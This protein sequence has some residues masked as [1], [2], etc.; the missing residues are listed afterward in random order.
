[1][2]RERD[3]SEQ[4][5]W[6]NAWAQSTQANLVSAPEPLAGAASPGA[7]QP[8]APLPPASE[9]VRS[10][11]DLIRNSVPISV[12]TPTST[13]GRVVGQT[14]NSR[15]IKTPPAAGGRATPLHMG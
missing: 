14:K 15:S 8:A 13:V 12:T 9:R 11:W 5:E 7:P 1:M 3:N 10:V 6:V 2:A 4:F